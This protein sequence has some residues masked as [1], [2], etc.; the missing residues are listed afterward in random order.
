MRIGGCGEVAISTISRHVRNKLPSAR[1]YSRKRLGKCAG[2]RFTHENLVYTQFYLDY[3]SHKDPSSVK[4][5][6][7]TGF[8]LPA[9]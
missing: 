2:E 5:F 1:K 3:L 7:E 4:F 6:D 9:G 8:Q